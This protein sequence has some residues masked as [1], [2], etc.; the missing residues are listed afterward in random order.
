MSETLTEYKLFEDKKT[1]RVFR[2]LINEGTSI[3]EVH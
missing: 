3:K 1:Q 2:Q